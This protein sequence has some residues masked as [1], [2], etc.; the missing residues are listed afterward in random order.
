V[1]RILFV[2]LARKGHG[3]SFKKNSTVVALER[4][5]QSQRTVKITGHMAPSNFPEFRFTLGVQLKNP[6]FEKKHIL[7]DITLLENFFPVKITNQSQ[8]SQ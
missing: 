8:D 7:T 1:N 3:L 6:L 4:F 5:I 2:V